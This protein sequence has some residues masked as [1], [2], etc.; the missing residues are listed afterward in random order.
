MIVIIKSAGS[1][2]HAWITALV[3]EWRISHKS[4]VPKFLAV[5]NARSAPFSRFARLLICNWKQKF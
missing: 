1:M 2:G 5:T 3:A 4:I